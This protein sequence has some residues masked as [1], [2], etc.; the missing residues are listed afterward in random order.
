MVL[1]W[2]QQWTVSLQVSSTICISLALPV[3]YCKGEHSGCKCENKVG[4]ETL[5]TNFLLKLSE[6]THVRHGRVG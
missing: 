2:F 6:F 1:A 5:E 3:W 4:N